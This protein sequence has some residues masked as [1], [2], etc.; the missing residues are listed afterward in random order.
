MKQQY[1]RLTILAGLLY[2]FMVSGAIAGYEGCGYKRQQLE[3]QLEYAQAYNNAHRVAG[4]QRAIWMK[5]GKNWQRP[6]ANFPA[7]LLSSDNCSILCRL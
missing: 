1:L 7:A 6:A 4:L 3:H 2:S 5:P